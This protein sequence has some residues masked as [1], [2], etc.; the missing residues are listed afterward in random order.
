MSSIWN[1]LFWRQT[2]ILLQPVIFV[3]QYPIELRVAQESINWFLQEIYKLIQIHFPFDPEPVSAVWV[4]TQSRINF[5]CL[6]W[7]GL[8]IESVLR[9]IPYPISVQW[10]D[11][12][13]ITV[14][15]FFALS[16]LVRKTWQIFLKLS[17]KINKIIIVL[18]TQKSQ[19]S[20]TASLRQLGLC[21]S[22]AV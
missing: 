14:L 9:V 19:L 7:T 12:L 11:L 15:V 8:R 6:Q 4:C 13:S 21:D 10:K 20:R 22:C 3:A 18:A 1:D 5:S 17:Y 2:T 16:I